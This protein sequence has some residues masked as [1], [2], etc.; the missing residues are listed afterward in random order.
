[1]IHSYFVTTISGLRYQDEDVED[2]NEIAKELAVDICYQLFSDYRIAP[3]RISA[4]VEEGVY[5]G[6]RTTDGGRYM[7]IEA[8][9]DGDV[10]ALVND[11]IE[12]K[13]LYCEETQDFAVAVRIFLDGRP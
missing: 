6:Y 4:T 10:C 1:V 9:N 11:E 8:Y 5:L 2:P 12:R 7:S 3:E 13:I